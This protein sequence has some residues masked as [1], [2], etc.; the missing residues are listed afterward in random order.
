MYMAFFLWEMDRERSKVNWG[1]IRCVEYV[2]SYQRK[3]NHWI[4]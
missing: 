1:V 2:V 4:T 3:R